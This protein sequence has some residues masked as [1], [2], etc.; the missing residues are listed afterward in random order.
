MLRT[1]VDVS[2]KDFEIA[3]DVEDYCYVNDKD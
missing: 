1:T 3:L 2:D